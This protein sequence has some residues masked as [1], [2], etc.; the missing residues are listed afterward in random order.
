MN[1]LFERFTPA[2]EGRPVVLFDYD[3]TI[4]KVPVDWPQARVAYRAYLADC[5][6]DLVIPESAR[7]DEMEAMAL[8]H[9]PDSKEQV[10]RFRFDLESALDGGHEALPEVCELIQHLAESG[11]SRLFIISNN[12]HRTVEAG[13]EQLRLSDAFE[14]ILGVDDVG[15]PKPETRAFTL[16][17]EAYGLSPEDCVFIGDNDRTDGGFCGALDIPFINIKD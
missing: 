1:N 10:F 3:S 17:Q 8:R 12:L 9:A 13:L 2:G 4:A 7:V 11:D 14:A 6:P 15:M 5:F 16:L